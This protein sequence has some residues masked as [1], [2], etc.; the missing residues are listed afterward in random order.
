M[1]R[2]QTF[3]LSGKGGTGELTWGKNMDCFTFSR[4]TLDNVIRIEYKGRSGDESWVEMSCCSNR[5]DIVMPWAIVVVAELVKIGSSLNL[6][7]RQNKFFR[8]TKSVTGI[9]KEM[10]EGEGERI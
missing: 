4:I 6:F 5:R 10:R 1:L 8:W 3:T 7:C 9:R 2:I